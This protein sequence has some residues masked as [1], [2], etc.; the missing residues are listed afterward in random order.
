[1]KSMLRYVL[2]ALASALVLAGSLR[3]QERAPWSPEIVSLFESLPVQDGG[4]VKPLYT[5]ASFTLLRFNGKRSV[6]LEGGERLTAT[7]WLLDVLFYPEVAR[8]YPIFL[9]QNPEVVTALG[10]SQEGKKRRDRYSLEELAPGVERL[11]QLGSEYH[12]IDEKQRTAVQ[13]QIFLLAT[14][15]Q[16]YLELETHLDFARKQVRIEGDAELAQV[17]GGNAQAP[18]SAVVDRMRPLIGLRERLAGDQDETR[19]RTVTE[20]LIQASELVARAESLALI[21]PA[22]DDPAD[23]PWLTPA[24][25]FFHA[26]HDSL[27]DEE[28]VRALAAFEGLVNVR[29]DRA[30]FTAQLRDLHGRLTGRAIARGD[31]QKVD[32]ELKYY[33]SK[34][35][36]YSHYGFVLAFLLMAGLWLRPRNR[37]FYGATSLAVLVSTL[38]LVAAITMRCMIRGRPPVSTLYETVL[39]V[40][41]VGA[42]IAL[43][44]ELVNRRR[45][46]V[47]AA[48]LMGMVGLFIANG[49]EMLDKRD[50]MPSLVAVL[51]TNFWLATHVT[52]IT[53]GY[54]AGMLAALLASIYIIAKAIGWRRADPGFYKSLGKMVY[55]VLCFAMIFS[56]VGTILG[57]VWANDS[58]GRFWGWDPKENGALLIVLSQ[59]VILHARMGGYLREHG[60]CMA[61]AFG[62][63]VIAFSWWG[64]NL[65]GVGL[66]SYGFT[67]GI[68]KAVWTYYIIQWGIVGLGAFTW[69]LERERARAVREAVQAPGS[70]KALEGWGSRA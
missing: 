30:A 59:L 61:T 60:I 3:A 25:V 42:L 50:T 12:R 65:L 55:G 43:F 57:G 63:T 22:V 39:F 4:R 23:A 29:D 31:Y 41:A 67:S 9:V 48:A 36:S 15:V 47:S 46:A 68:S 8:G 49:Y 40:T 34:V 58:W 21:P 10:V 52:A 28:G 7:E 24:D 69:Y 32:L 38:L 27:A 13:Q 6:R 17:F 53:T 51:D 62:G 35:L 44:V 2:P 66:H 26:F 33:K 1:M 14:N 5:H 45:I 19:F 18:V 54:S 11:F 20:P 70:D 64:V 16:A 37:G 56:V